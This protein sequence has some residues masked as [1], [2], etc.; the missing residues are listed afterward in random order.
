MTCSNVAVEFLRQITH[1]DSE[2]H[3]SPSEAHVKTKNIRLFQSP[4]LYLATT[5]KAVPA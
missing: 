1:R 3:L 4:Q 5:L 2:D